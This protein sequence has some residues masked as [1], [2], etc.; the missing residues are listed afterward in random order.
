MDTNQK[1]ETAS[2][3]S[4]SLKRAAKRDEDEALI[5]LQDT[6]GSKQFKPSV[7]TYQEIREF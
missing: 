2:P 1:T 7:P 5:L 6:A 4:A 3:N